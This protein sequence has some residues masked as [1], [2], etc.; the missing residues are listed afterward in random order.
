[1][2]LS[3]NNS[4]YRSAREVSEENGIP[5]QFLRRIFKKLCEINIV[6]TKEG[7]LGGVKIN[8]KS[9]KIKV[10]DIIKI[11]QGDL[12]LSACMFRKKICSNRKTCVFRKK[13]KSIEK[14]IEKEFEDMTIASLVRDAEA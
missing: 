12:Q 1:M 8:K 2:Y 7:K 4:R 9:G 11:F 6:E 3:L 5:Y 13:I 14:I 10:L